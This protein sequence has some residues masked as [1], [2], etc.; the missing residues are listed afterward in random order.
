MKTLTIH[1]DEKNIRA[2]VE[3]ATGEVQVYRA[4]AYCLHCKGIRVGARVYPAP[5][6]KAMQDMSR[7]RGAE[8]LLL[9]AQLQFNTLVRDGFAIECDD[10]ENKGFKSR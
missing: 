4:C 8:D 6:E 1:R 9:N 3:C 2:A 10:D 5:Q 7:G